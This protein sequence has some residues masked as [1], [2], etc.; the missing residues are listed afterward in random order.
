VILLDTNVV[1]ELM[2]PR[3]EARVTA[4]LAVRRLETLFLPSLV[5]AEIRYG[6]AR[7]PDG[8]RRSALE[9]LFGRFLAEGFADRVLP[10]DASCAPHYADARAAREAAGRPV[11]LAD[12]LI[13]GMALAHGATLAT[14]NTADFDG[15]GLSLL[16]PWK[17]A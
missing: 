17:T 2:R 13:G 5:V 14:R 4:F 3:P 7:L 1:S 10:F 12:A 9:D 6:L 11:A 15:F 8:S 16:N